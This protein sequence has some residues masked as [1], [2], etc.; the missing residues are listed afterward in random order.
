MYFYMLAHQL[1]EDRQA[2]LTRTIFANQEAFLS[3]VD[4]SA[5]PSLDAKTDVA[6]H[7]R[8]FLAQMTALLSET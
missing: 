4:L 3:S 2:F 6:A 8:E 5:S 7:D 1:D